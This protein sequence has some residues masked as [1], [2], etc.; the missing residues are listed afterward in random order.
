LEVN[1]KIG[2]NQEAVMGMDKLFQIPDSSIFG[3]WILSLV[4]Y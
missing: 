3:Y 4:S 1:G 2:N